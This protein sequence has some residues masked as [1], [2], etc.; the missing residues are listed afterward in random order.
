MLEKLGIT[1]LNKMQREAYDAILRGKQDVVVLSP[2][3]S[4]KTL[5]YLLPLAQMV[6]ARLAEVQAL[7][8][9]PGSS[10]RQGHE[11]YG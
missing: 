8:V 2:T 7:V 11:G 10:V 4:G 1:E 3:G 9:V 6:D 5:A